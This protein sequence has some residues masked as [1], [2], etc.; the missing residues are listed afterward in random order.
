MLG[1]KYTDAVPP[2]IKQCI[3]YLSSPKILSTKD[4]FQSTS[5]NINTSHQVMDALKKDVSVD[6]E[7]YKDPFMVAAILKQLFREMPEPLLTYELYDDIVAFNNLRHKLAA[8][9]VLI[10][11]RLPKNNFKLL[12]FLLAFL[13]RIIEYNDKNK[14]SARKVSNIFSPLIIR[15]KEN[16]NNMTELALETY[17]ATEFLKFL[18]EQFLDVFT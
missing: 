5:Y 8:A 16:H 10:L 7:D 4:L 2:A 11:Y 18:L 15:Q 3:D 6:L 12:E 17:D 1:S 14:M 9:K 13:L